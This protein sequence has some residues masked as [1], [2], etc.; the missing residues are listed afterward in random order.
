MRYD[1]TQKE[2]L[3]DALVTLCLLDR[4]A[5]EGPVGDRLKVVKL[6]FLATWE[7]FQNRWKGLNFSFYRYTYG[8]FTPQL[9]E[10]WEE[11]SWAGLLEIGSGPDGKIALTEEGR[12]LAQ[13]VWREVFDLP[14][15]RAFAEVL[16]RIAARHGG[17]D[18]GQI[19]R[20]VYLLQAPPASGGR[21]VPIRDM[22]SGTYITAC[23]EPEDADLR[24]DIPD[25]LL[26]EFD[27]HRS[28]HRYQRVFPGMALLPPERLTKVREAI[29]AMQRGGRKAYSA[30]EARRRAGLE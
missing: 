27:A 10:T 17:Q 26:S 21:P 14:R 24:L 1:R 7:M 15:H 22:A 28:W 5:L 6:V 16:D 9:Y 30:E 20:H 13:R 2:A 19:L 11:L 25:Q 18:T 29:E 4:S 8:P 3:A 23:L 12:S